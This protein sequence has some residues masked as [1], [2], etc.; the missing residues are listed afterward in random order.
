MGRTPATWGVLK[1][2]QV[3][4]PMVQMT[5]A[6]WK[7]LREV[8]IQPSVTPFLLLKLWSLAKGPIRH[9][10]LMGQQHMQKMTLT[11]ELTGQKVQGKPLQAQVFKVGLP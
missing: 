1:M 5:F 2:T 9:M 11:V 6:S 4:P 3:C 7:T 10:A 8:P